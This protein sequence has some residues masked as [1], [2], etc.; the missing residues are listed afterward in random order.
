MSS[1][2]PK[3]FTTFCRI[4]SAATSAGHVFG[5][6]MNTPYFENRST[7]TK[8]DMHPVTFG[9]PTMKSILIDCHGFSGM[10]RGCNSPTSC[11]RSVLSCWHTR[12]VLT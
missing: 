11:L 2:N 5:A 8:I 3:Y 6:G 10:G 9:N 4:N 1:G 7:T 12:H